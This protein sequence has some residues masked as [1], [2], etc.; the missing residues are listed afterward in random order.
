MKNTFSLQSLQSIKN[1]FPLQ[2]SKFLLMW[3]DDR[4]CSSYWVPRSDVHCQRLLKEYFSKRSSVFETPESH[5]NMPLVNSVPDSGAGV[6]RTFV[7]G[8]SISSDNRPQGSG[9]RR[10]QFSD[11]STSSS[12][13]LLLTSNSSSLLKNHLSSSRLDYKKQL[14][15]WEKQINKKIDGKEPRIHIEN[16]VDQSP[17]PSNFTYV[18]KSNMVNCNIEIDVAATPGCNC[19]GACFRSSE[20]CPHRMNTEVA[21]NQ[22]GYI[23]IPPGYPI[24]EC[25][26][27]CFCDPTCFNRVVQRGRQVPLCVFRTSNGRGWGVKTMQTLSKGQFVSEYIGEIISNEEAEK[28]GKKYDQ[29]GSTYLF[30]LDFDKD[31]AAFTIDATNCG[32]ISHFL[33]HS[34]S[35]KKCKSISSLISTC[36]D[37]NTDQRSLNTVTVQIF[38]V[39]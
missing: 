36:I 15:K 2:S 27:S 39:A 18:C 22:R 4:F 26:A 7:N 14:R 10:V 33:N 34:V 1:T 25:N 23:K 11:E 5:S 30:D 37:L 20:C 29:T 21:Y 35:I 17:I 6:N 9:T 31:D 16:T 3:A 28:R 19:S 38:M 13:Q 8:A 24:Y 32:N 12:R